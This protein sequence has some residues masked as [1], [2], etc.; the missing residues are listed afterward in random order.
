MTRSRQFF[1]GTRA[2]IPVGGKILPSA[3]TGVDPSHDI[4][5]PN[6]VYMERGRRKAE[7]S[8]W[9]WANHAW[10]DNGHPYPERP[11][12]GRVK[13]S[14]GVSRG[15]TFTEHTASSAKVKERFDIKPGHQGTF[16]NINWNQ[17]ASVNWMGVE[18]N[19]PSDEQIM[20]GH[21][22]YQRKYRTH[23]LFETPRP[24]DDLN[25]VSRRFEY[26]RDDPDPGQG[27]LF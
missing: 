6:H 17:F 4:S 27:R 2:D 26:D 16:P 15:M 19:H 7:E 21:D 9:E 1:H 22:T 23:S 14:K 18:L 25:H 3:K 24:E 5:S 12:V 20:G 11:W 8:A 13:P 10:V